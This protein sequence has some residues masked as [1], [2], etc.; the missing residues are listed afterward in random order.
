[1][2]A[3]S[4]SSIPAAARMSAPVQTETTVLPLAA[5]KFQNLRIFSGVRS[6]AEPA[7]HNKQI[8]SWRFLQDAIRH[9][10]QPV[11]AADI[12]VRAAW[13][14]CIGRGTRGWTEM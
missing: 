14:K 5:Y 6:R 13:E 3:E 2:V 7:G 8:K 11:A 9:N 12:W 10:L 1:M 4:P